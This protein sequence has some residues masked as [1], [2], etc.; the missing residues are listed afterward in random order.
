MFDAAKYRFDHHQRSF[1]HHW[2]TEEDERREAERAKAIEKGENPEVE[3]PNK[4]VTKL[5]SAGLIFKYF[6]KEIITNTCKS[7]YDMTLNDSELEHIYQKL[8]RGLFLEVDAVDNGV[9]IA[10]DTRYNISTSLS[11]RVGYMNS[12]WNAPQTAGYSQHIQFKKA[13]R[14]TEEAFFS[15][16]YGIVHIMMPA[17]K[18]V[19]EAWN[20]RHQFH[21]CGEFIWFE[22][23]CPWKEHLLDIE[24][25]ND[26][27]GHIKFAFY[28]DGRNMFRIQALPSKVGQ[29]DNRVSL[30]KAMRGLRGEQLNSV[31]GVTDAEFVHAAGFIGGAWSKESALKMAMDSLKEH[32]EE[33]EMLSRLEL[34]K[35]QKT[36]E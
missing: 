21:E 14:L 5:S 28:Q 34:E 6:G 25:E 13:M 20:A 15:E 2:W 7:E 33:Q 30:A 17:R 18:I 24:K 31:A 3:K 36:C 29:F 27:H 4:V 32:N 23:T 12:P 26:L 8:Y 16:L 10:D 1:T 35:K 19:L 9:N 11:A 22:K